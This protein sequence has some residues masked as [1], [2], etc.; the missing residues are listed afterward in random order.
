MALT[1]LLPPSTMEPLR[2]AYT[3]GLADARHNANK[4]SGEKNIRRWPGADE[5]KKGGRRR[6]RGKNEW[7]DDG[8]MLE[9]TAKRLELG[10]L[11]N[12]HFG[13][14]D[15]TRSQFTNAESPLF[16]LAEIGRAHV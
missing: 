14:T 16:L 5:N 10:A 1:K 12:G 8:M 4:E 15:V 2:L 11:V 13:Y 7:L 9:R 6:R 3:G